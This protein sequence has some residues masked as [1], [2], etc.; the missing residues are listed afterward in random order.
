L[1]VLQ[2][3]AANPEAV[4]TLVLANQLGMDRRTLLC[5]CRRLEK[6]ELLRRVRNVAIGCGALAWKITEKTRDFLS[7]L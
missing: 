1:A 6:A 3:V 4:G 5:Q 7:S 2:G